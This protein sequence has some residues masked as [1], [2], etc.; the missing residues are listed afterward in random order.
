MPQCLVTLCLIYVI[1]QTI[2]LQ[3]FISKDAL[4]SSR[5]SFGESSFVEVGLAETSLSSGHHLLSQQQQQLPDSQEDQAVICCNYFKILKEIT[6]V[7][8]N[9][10]ADSIS[11]T[12]SSE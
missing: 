4:E 5:I 1:Y 10:A 3:M 2:L 6:I 8:N 11:T 9:A 7:E 12:S